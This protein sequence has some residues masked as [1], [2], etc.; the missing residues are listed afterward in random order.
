MF[1]N[2]FYRDVAKATVALFLVLLL[3]RFTGGAMS[4]VIVLTGIVAALARKPG[5]TVICY[6]MIPVLQVFNR[7]VVGMS[8]L[9]FIVGRFGGPLII[10]AL[11]ASGMANR[12]GRERLPIGW[13]WAYLVV[14]CI[15]SFDGWMPMVSYFKIAYFAVMLLGLIVVSKAI[16]LRERDLLLLRIMF[17][18]LAV[19]MIVGSVLSYFV[20]SVG[21]SM[22]IY[23]MEGYGM[24]VTGED[25]VQH[26]GAVFFNGMTCHSQALAPIVIS[27][28][29]WVL[30]D[31]IY[32]ER[33]FC[34]LHV[35]ILSFVPLLAY[36]SRSRGA[37]LEI[38]AVVG[39]TWIF[40][41]PHARIARS[42]K[43]HLRGLLTLGV[44]LL[45]VVAVFFEIRNNAISRWLRKTDDVQKDTRTLR[46][47]FTSS[48]QG[49]I[50]MNLYDFKQN[51]LFGK[52]F[53]VTIFMQMAS[54]TKDFNWFTAAVE[55]GVTPFV[56][57]GE[58]GLCGAF[59]FLLFMVSFYTACLRRRYLSLMTCF[60]CFLVAN[61]ADSTF[62][63]PS[64]LGGFMWV[65]SCVGGF[66][67]DMLAR[68]MDTQQTLEWQ[69]TL[70]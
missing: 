65:L 55:K 58:T 6:L 7:A 67:T 3:C 39:V 28:A 41:L 27:L 46:E 66:S 21:Y 44:V 24:M 40:G 62:F 31:M 36:M 32:V 50:D 51:P 16:Q 26:E 2:H 8:S 4:I 18:A 20:P 56:I 57:L 22:M 47:A 61:L 30:G 10:V 19:I 70:V 68:R 49:M 53:Q 29:A 60:T 63:S 52:G 64:Y 45:I 48:R 33:R 5:L 35:G 11:L 69:P 12:G 38:M 14:A 43:G 59:V 17:M 9:Q 42:M 25:I 1:K 34:A 54:R 37:F 23:K 13:L 15:S